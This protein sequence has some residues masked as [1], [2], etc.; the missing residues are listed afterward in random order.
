MKFICSGSELAQAAGIVG[1]ML[2]GKSNIPVLDGINIKAQGKTVTL[3]VYNQEVYIQKTINAEILEDGEIVVEG[4]LFIDYTNKISNVDKIE[5]DVASK[6][7]LTIKFGFSDFQMP[8]F[9]KEN[10]PSL[11]KYTKEYYFS[12]KERDLKELIDRA[13]FCISVNSATRVILRSCSFSVKDED[14]EA[15]CLDGFR[16]A[17]SKKKVVGQ[18]GN[19]NFIIYGK[20]LS[21]IMKIIGD[22]DNEITVSKEG[23]MIMFDLGHTKIKV[24]TIDGEFYNYKNTIPTDIKNEITVKKESLVGCLDRAAV[25]CRDIMYNK[26][27]LNIESKMMNINTLSEKGRVN[28]NI[29]CVNNGEDIRIAL[30]CRFLQDAISRIKEDFFKITVERPT[31]PIL[32]SAMEGDEYKCIILPLKLIG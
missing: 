26:I 23:G 21:D 22:N 7:L 27:T 9:E 5:L 8:Y 3:S 28:E 25:V 16:V 20:H 11:G 4:K 31:K 30:N 10:F 2:S 32:I 6:E 18:N 13:L 12:L 24:T 1:K 14:V 19:I 15:V 29:D 17:V